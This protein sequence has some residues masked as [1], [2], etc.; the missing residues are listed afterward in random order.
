MQG[1]SLSV[2]PTSGHSKQ[3]GFIMFLTK[4]EKKYYPH[5]IVVIKVTGR[6]TSVGT[7]LLSQKSW[8][9]SRSEQAREL[10]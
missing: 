6:D 10:A 2:P 1:S 4:H 7:R 8:F 3:V 5:L 9:R